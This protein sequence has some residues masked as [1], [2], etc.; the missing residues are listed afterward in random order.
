VLLE[1]PGGQIAS[2]LAGAFLAL[3]EGDEL[4]LV[5]GAEHEVEGGGGM[6]EPASAEFFTSGLGARLSI[7]HGSDSRWSQAMDSKCLAILSWSPGSGNATAPS[8]GFR[9]G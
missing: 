4:V 3:V 2:Q 5:F 6:A 9:V 8:F 1:E 7:I